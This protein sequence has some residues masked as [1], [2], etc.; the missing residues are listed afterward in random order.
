MELGSSPS[1]FGVAAERFLS[2][3][4][5]NPHNRALLEHL[6]SLGLNDAWLVAGC[7]FQTFWNLEHGRPATEG[8]RDYDIFYFDEDLSFEAEDRQIGRVGEILRDMP[9]RV[10]LKNQARVHLWYGERFG[11]GYPQLRSS[12]DGVDHFLIECTRV[13]VRKDATGALELYAPGALDD[14]FGGILRPNPLNLRP[15]LFAAKAESLRARW[16]WLVI[17]DAAG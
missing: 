16:P 2:L 3:I 8:I 4:V 7:L 17:D 6:P 1:R 12:R 13:A 5:Q 15:A 11:P 14:L 9:V 10:D